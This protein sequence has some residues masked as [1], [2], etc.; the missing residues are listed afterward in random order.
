[1]GTG[2]SGRRPCRVTQGELCN[3]YSAPPMTLATT[4]DRIRIILAK[5]LELRPNI[6]AMNA[7]PAAAILNGSRQASAMPNSGR[8]TVLD[9]VAFSGATWLSSKSSIHRHQN[10]VGNL[11]PEEEVS[12]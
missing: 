2:C 10:S 9:R 3:R 7:V 8:K 12:L 5:A 4:P 6:C 1:N 11:T